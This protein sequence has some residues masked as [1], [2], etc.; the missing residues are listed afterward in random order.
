M[1]YIRDFEPILPDPQPYVAKALALYERAVRDGRGRVVFIAAELGGGKTEHLSALARELS[2]AKPAPNFLAGFFSDG[3][4]YRYTFDWQENICLKK[5]VI[6]AGGATALLGLLPGPYAFAAAFVGQ[7][8]QT[9]VSAHEFAYEFTKDPPQRKESAGWLKNLWR[10]A[11]AE[12]PLVCLLDDWHE[13][14][15]FQ[16]DLMLSSL[17]GEI[18]RD[19]PLLLFITVKSPLNFDAP[20]KDESGLT[21]VIKR[22]TEKGLAEYWPLRK[23]SQHEI[24][25]TIGDAAPGIAAKLHGLTG[26]NARWVREIWHE[27]RVNEIV[28][29]SDTDQWAWGEHQ[30]ESLNLYKDILE[31]RLT[32]LLKTETAIE[33][34]EARELLA[35]AALEGVSFTA[36][37]LARAM[38]WDRDE[39][40]DF[41]DEALVQSEDNPDGLLLEDEAVNIPTPDGATRTLWRYRFVSDLHWMALERYGFSNEQR[42]ERSDTERLEKCAALAEALI[43]NYAPEERLV[44]AQLAR[45]LREIG[46]HEAAQRYQRMS[47]YAAKREV[48]REQALYLLTVSKDDW[49]QW[50]YEN[51]ARFLIEAGQAMVNAFPY[52]ETLA[53]LEEAHKMAQRAKSYQD[54]AH[55]LYLSGFILRA[56][57]EYTLARERANDSLDICLRIRKKDGIAASLI[58]LAQIDLNEGDY[59][60]AR[61]RTTQALQIARQ[62]GDQNNIGVTLQLLAHIDFNEEKYAEAREHVTQALKIKRER[63]NRHGVA[64][65]LTVLAQLESM[66]GNYTEAR[67]LATEVLEIGRELGD[68]DSIGETLLLLAYIDFHEGRYA[69]SLERATQS[70]KINREIGDRR[71]KANV[72]GLLSDVAGKLKL[73]HEAFNLTALGFRILHHIGADDAQSAWNCLGS[74]VAEQEYTEAQFDKLFRQVS[75][76]YQANG[77]EELIDKSLARL[78]EASG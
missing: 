3:Q 77:G 63:G 49:D 31:D 29:T 41:L 78:R 16:W 9:S 44:A 52:Q 42:P 21:A 8:L 72:L 24:A 54:E 40:I 74:L 59:V 15:R 11:A 50:Q 55:A 34:E 22:L 53:V 61:E 51:V 12:K 71:G 48:M 17:A 36:D 73:P 14:Q 37:A 5:A 75:A 4:Y 65:S 7:L 56:E 28:V 2:Q 38:N 27:W 1:T 58:L 43:E 66:E 35:C 45:L 70:L 57:G 68:R 67:A 10:R 64:V 39:L 19:L 23:L 47:D 20:E 13:A 18:G 60:K 69:E 25:A 62:Q 6:A 26:G 76:A 33:I 32:R 46:Q 30:K